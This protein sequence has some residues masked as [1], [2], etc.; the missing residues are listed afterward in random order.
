MLRLCP[1]NP[2][3]PPYPPFSISKIQNVTPVSEYEGIRAHC[4]G[5]RHEDWGG[6][7]QGESA[8][9]ATVTMI[10]ENGGYGGWGGFSGHRRSTHQSQYAQS[11]NNILDKPRKIL[12]EEKVGEEIDEYSKAIGQEC[13]TPFRVAACRW[14]NVSLAFQKLIYTCTNPVLP[15][16][17]L[18]SILFVLLHQYGH[19]FSWGRECNAQARPKQVVIRQWHSEAG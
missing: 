15:S 19:P 2:P 9:S 7:G 1:E 13:A 8:A 18:K 16:Q 10:M 5:G 12:G 4:Q 3:H 11:L 6:G 14:R 17:I